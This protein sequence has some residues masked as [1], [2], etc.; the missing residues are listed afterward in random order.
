MIIIPTFNR[1][2]KLNRTLHFYKQTGILDEIDVIVLD[3][4]DQSYLEKNR[5]VCLELSVKYIEDSGSGLI[6]RLWS[7]ISDIPDDQIIALGNDEDCF[8]PSYLRNASEFLHDHPDYVSFIGSYVTQERPLFK[9][10]KRVSS[11]RNVVTNFDINSNDPNS[12]ISTLD[13]IIIAGCSP[14]YFSMRRAKNFKDSI[15]QQ[16]LNEYL[17]TREVLDQVM[18]AVG[19]KI[20]FSEDVMLLRDETKIEYQYLRDRQDEDTYFNDECMLLALT[21]LTETYPKCAASLES[22]FEIRKPNIKIGEDKRSN[23]LLEIHRKVN[24]QLSLPHTGFLNKIIMFSI[25]NSNRALRVLS[26]HLMYRFYRTQLEK[27][28]SK[29]AVSNLFTVIETNKL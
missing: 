24:L 13:K 22:F 19:G 9:F 18:L 26:E 29:A 4:S 6:D 16:K 21:R 5:A 3:G 27:E 20:Y 25:S 15:L 17:T 14:V 8:H 11:R 23:L 1:S 28:F 10:F 7:F 12:R 2:A